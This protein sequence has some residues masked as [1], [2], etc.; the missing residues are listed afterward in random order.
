MV[1]LHVVDDQIIDGAAVEYVAN[2]FEVGFGAAGLYGVDESYLFVYN[3]I[4]V[5]GDSIREG[6]QCLEFV[7]FAI[8]GSHI[9][10]VRCNFSKMVH[11]IEVY[12]EISR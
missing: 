12:F 9:V 7:G 8:V 1:G 2:V 10:D 5:V 6:P 11:M 3:Q 4:G